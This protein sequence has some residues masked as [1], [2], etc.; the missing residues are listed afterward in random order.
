MNIRIKG[1]NISLTPAISDYIAKRLEKASSLLGNDPSIQCDV[2]VGRSAGHQSKGEVF[3]AEVHIVGPG[4]NMY[5]SS[6]KEDLYVAIDDVRD[7]IIREITAAKGKRM[8]LVRRSG[9]RVKGVMKGL[10]PWKK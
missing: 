6:D 1:T 9:A 2:E 7:E 4:K 3:R 5:A 10:W 8:S